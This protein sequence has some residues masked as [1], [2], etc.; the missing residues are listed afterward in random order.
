MPFETTGDPWVRLV[1]PGAALDVGERYPRM[2]GLPRWLDDHRFAY[3]GH[4]AC[5]VRDVVAG[6]ATATPHPDFADI[7]AVGA[8]GDHWFTTEY[9][10]QVT[11]HV[12]TN[13]DTRPWAPGR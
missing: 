6:T 10:G 9:V 12:I 8:G 4:A 1:A 7:L 11:R 3:C 13:F 2:P 5:H